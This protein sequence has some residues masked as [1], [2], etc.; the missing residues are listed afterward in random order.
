M[1]VIEDFKN[2]LLGIYHNRIQAYNYPRDWAYIFIEFTQLNNSNV[3]S[4]SWYAIEG[5][6]NPYKEVVLSFYENDDSIIV[7]TWDKNDNPLFDVEFNYLD[8]YWIGEN[9]RCEMENKNH[10]ISTSVKF[11]GKNYFSR[12]SGH[13]ILTDEFLWGKRKS[14]GM[15]HFIKE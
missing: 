6:G 1:R 14:E 4:K 10:Y 15:F 5:Y 8:G 13:D 3:L 9:D 12:D 7:K 11:D 2:K